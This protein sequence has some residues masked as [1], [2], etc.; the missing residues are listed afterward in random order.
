MLAKEKSRRKARNGAHSARWSG[1]DTRSGGS[2]YY[3][4]DQGLGVEAMDLTI[5]EERAVRQVMH[6]C[7]NRSILRRMERKDDSAQ[8]QPL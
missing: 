8:T 1:N 6:T 3:W 7:M 2:H 4:H 5:K